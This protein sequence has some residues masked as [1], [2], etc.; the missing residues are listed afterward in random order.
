M[1]RLTSGQRR[2]LVENVPELANFAAGSLLFGQFLS[3]RPYSLALALAGIVA[4]AALT[5]IA[6]FFAAGE[7]R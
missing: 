4:W 6:L 1:L 5:G 2:V 3:E 7:R